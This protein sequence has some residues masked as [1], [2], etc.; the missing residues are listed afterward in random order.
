MDFFANLAGARELLPAVC[1]STGL[2][3]RF[4]YNKWEGSEDGTKVSMIGVFRGESPEAEDETLTLIANVN[5]ECLFRMIETA[6]PAEEED[7]RSHSG[8]SDSSSEDLGEDEELPRS[9]K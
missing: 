9:A 8:G 1:I 7:S 2:Y 6:R 4:K 5:A 3:S